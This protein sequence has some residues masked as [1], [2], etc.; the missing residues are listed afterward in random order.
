MAPPH[1]ISGLS[2]YSPG[3]WKWLAV[4]HEA[5]WGAEWRPELPQKALGLGDP[6]A[7]LHL[8][9]RPYHLQ[10]SHHQ[11]L[12]LLS[13]Q[14]NCISFSKEHVLSTHPSK[15]VSHAGEQ[16]RFPPPGSWLNQDG[17][18]RVTGVYRN[19]PWNDVF[20]SC[21]KTMYCGPVCFVTMRNAFVH[22]TFLEWCVKLVIMGLG[23]GHI[24]FFCVC[25]FLLF[26]FFTEPKLYNNF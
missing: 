3:S 8:P 2:L 12:P 20:K 25:P 17:P 13:G 15:D 21:C 14:S 5:A 4:A 1:R 18:G 24:G 19:T 7:P 26:E 9:P 22:R 10:A 11:E 16:S 23:G 6:Q